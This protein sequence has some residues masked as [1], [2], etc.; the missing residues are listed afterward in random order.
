MMAIFN[1]NIRF[2]L[3]L[4]FLRLCPMCK[5]G[6][7]GPSCCACATG[8]QFVGDYLGLDNCVF[9]MTLTFAGD[10][11]TTFTGEF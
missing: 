4:R 5:L 8:S 11:C 7:E 9:N 1:K 6:F 3:L 10:D 2:L